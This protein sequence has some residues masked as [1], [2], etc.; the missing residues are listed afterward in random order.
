M[1][2]SPS[3]IFLN[4]SNLN[5][6]RTLLPRRMDS[7]SRRHTKSELRALL[8]SRFAEGLLFL[9]ASTA[10]CNSPTKPSC[11]DK[12]GLR[13]LPSLLSSWG[14]T[15]QD[16]LYFKAAGLIVQDNHFTIELFFQAQL[17]IGEPDP[18]VK[19]L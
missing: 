18:S 1:F 13:T 5:Q 17:G 16:E 12:R 3:L 8:P 10:S 9:M 14:G 6:T 19:E 4:Q 11:F 2:L 15:P 7:N